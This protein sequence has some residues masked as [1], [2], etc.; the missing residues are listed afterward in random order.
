MIKMI[1]WPV[2]LVCMGNP[3]VSQP[4]L[5]MAKQSIMH[6]ISILHLQEPVSIKLGGTFKWKKRKVGHR[7]VKVNDTFQYIPL[8]ESL[9]VCKS[10]KTLPMTYTKYILGTITK[11]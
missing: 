5:I 7:I 2:N 1:K 11:G 3:R 9:K 10:N 6:L 4:F 8:L